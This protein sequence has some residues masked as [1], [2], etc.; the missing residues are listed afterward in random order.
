MIKAALTASEGLGK[1]SSEH[2]AVGTTAAMITKQLQ[3]W[4]VGIK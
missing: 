1:S 4:V 3:D 2:K